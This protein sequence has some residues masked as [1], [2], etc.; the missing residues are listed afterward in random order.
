MNAV[1]SGARIPSQP[2]SCNLRISCQDRRPHKCTPTYHLYGFHD[3]WRAFA[4]MN[5]PHMSREALMWHQSPLTTARYINTARPPLP[6]D[7]PEGI[8][9]RWKSP[10]FTAY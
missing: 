3:E 9:A 5:A 7:L 4:T 8:R 6:T 2:I 10:T 1:G